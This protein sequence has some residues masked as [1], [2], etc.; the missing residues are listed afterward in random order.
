[1]SERPDG[2]EN[3]TGEA[4]YLYSNLREE[5][6]EHLVVGEL[7]R[8]LWR[9]GNFDVEVSHSEF[10]GFGY[11]LVVELN[12]IVR[13]IQLKSSRKTGRQP[14]PVT[15]SEGLSRK[16]DGCVI[17]VDV[18]DE[19]NLGP[20]HWFGSAPGL[21]F[22]SLKGFR[23]AQRI[24]RQASGAKVLRKKHFSVPRS[25]FQEVKRVE[26]LLELLFA[27]SRN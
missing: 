15:V 21:G 19:L 4:H 16:R 9:L 8:V 25:S 23:P 12:G 11:D 22:P 26:D 24:G 14:K 13:H 10:D 7:L 2:R 27:L 18:D 6:V 3:A 5:I 20:F 1:V 17:W